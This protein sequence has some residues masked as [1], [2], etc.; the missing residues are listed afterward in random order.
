MSV[1]IADIDRSE[2]IAAIAADN[3]ERKSADRLETLRRTEVRKLKYTVTP[4]RNR[5][6]N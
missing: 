2:R 5:R 1:T 3:R 6:G 4:V